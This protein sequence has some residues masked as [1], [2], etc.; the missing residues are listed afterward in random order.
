[1]KTTKFNNI[2]KIIYFANETIMFEMVKK[3][4][5]CTVSMSSRFSPNYL[6]CMRT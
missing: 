3:D 4:N 1:M 2:M 5:M 6:F